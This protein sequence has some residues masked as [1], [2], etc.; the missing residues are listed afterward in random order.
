MIDIGNSRTYGNNCNFTLMSGITLGC[1]ELPK[2]I[3]NFAYPEL[4]QLTLVMKQ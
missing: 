4:P 1:P 2:A 3:R